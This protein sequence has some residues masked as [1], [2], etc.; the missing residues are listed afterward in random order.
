M[1]TMTS[2]NALSSPGMFKALTR[3]LY[4][5]SFTLRNPTLFQ[6][7]VNLTLFSLHSTVHPYLRDLT[8]AK[9]SDLALV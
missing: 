8:L 9:K 5:Y 6:R 1:V 3:A 2:P 7:A 4:F